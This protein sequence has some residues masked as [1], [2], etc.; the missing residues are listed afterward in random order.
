MTTSLTSIPCSLSPNPPT[1]IFGSFVKRYYDVM[2]SS[3]EDLYKFYKE[4]S[5]F[6]HFDALQLG[7]SVTGVENIKARIAQLSF[8]GIR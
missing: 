5:F 4:D 7:D 2:F 3:P 8:Q 1:Y 6:M